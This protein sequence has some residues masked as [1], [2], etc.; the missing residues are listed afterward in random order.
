MRLEH[1]F[2]LFPAAG[3]QKVLPLRAFWHTSTVPEAERDQ[4]PRETTMTAKAL[5]EHF[6]L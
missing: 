6:L 4:E 3:A 1:L 5:Q 2:L